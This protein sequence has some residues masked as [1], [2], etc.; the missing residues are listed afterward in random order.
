M[1]APAK[2]KPRNRKAPGLHTLTLFSGLFNV[3]RNPV[4]KRHIGG[5]ARGRAKVNLVAG[6]KAAN[7][8][9]ETGGFHDA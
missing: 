8:G 2:K 4:T 1:P 9:H 7:L 3:A 6:A 5:I